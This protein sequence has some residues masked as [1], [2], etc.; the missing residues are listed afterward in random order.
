MTSVR[1]SLFIFCL[2]GSAV[3]SITSV[4]QVR[5]SNHYEYSDVLFANSYM[6]KVRS[7]TKAAIIRHFNVAA[8]KLSDDVNLAS[9]GINIGSNDAFLMDIEEE[10]EMELPS[11]DSRQLET[12]K[13]IV[14]Y[15]NEHL[16]GA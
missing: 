8:D 10:F 7:F 4:A 11:E 16:E 15:I 14:E 12:L 2:V 13:E 6:D 1:I 5:Q 3:V 9:L